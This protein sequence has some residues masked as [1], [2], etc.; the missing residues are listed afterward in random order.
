[1]INPILWGTSKFFGW[2]LG[3]L[4]SSLWRRGLPWASPHAKWERTLW[5][6]AAK[7]MA[8]WGV[9]KGRALEFAKK[10]GLYDTQKQWR[11]TYNQYY[12][13]S[14]ARGEFA[15]IGANSPISRDIFRNS[16][17]DFPETSGMAMRKYYH[18]VELGYF[19][20]EGNET[21]QIL[22]ITTD[23]ILTPLQVEEN[24][25]E[26]VDDFS[27][28][29]SLPSYLLEQEPPTIKYVDSMHHY[30]WEW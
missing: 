12:N 23:N 19:D 6:M 11:A 30:G 21:T 15:K 22:T 24:A 2:R 5:N 9:P 26:Y 3:L 29:D 7:S 17:F 14:G 4:G 18:H 8:S 25:Q 28:Q 16:A 20:T 10:W 13:V 1:M 27:W